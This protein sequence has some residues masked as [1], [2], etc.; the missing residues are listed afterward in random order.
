M[1]RHQAIIRSREDAARRAEERRLQASQRKEEQ[2]SRL[3]THLA[4]EE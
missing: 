1:E 2:L 4:E 3:R